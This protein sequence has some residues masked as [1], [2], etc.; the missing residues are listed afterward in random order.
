MVYVPKEGKKSLHIEECMEINLLQI[1]M[2][3]TIPYFNHPSRNF[4]S[5]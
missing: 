4:D 2:K 3:V 1:I 5:W